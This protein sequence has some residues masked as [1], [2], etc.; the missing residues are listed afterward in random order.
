MR[1]AFTEVLIIYSICERNSKGLA[2]GTNI[3]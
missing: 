1:A 3:I 2:A